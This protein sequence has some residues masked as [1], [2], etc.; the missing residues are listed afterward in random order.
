MLSVIALAET[1]TAS[2]DKPT[3]ILYDTRVYLVLTYN[4][5]QGIP[6]STISRGIN[7][8][9]RLCGLWPGG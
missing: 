3:G 1:G 5:Y 2:T 8:F 6:D 4:V 7:D 9:S